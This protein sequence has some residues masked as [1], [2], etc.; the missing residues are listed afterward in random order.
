[1]SL[2]SD[3]G[4]FIGQAQEITDQLHTAKDEVVTSA[5]DA[6]LNGKETV[7]DVATELSSS[8]SSIQETATQA[9]EDI[10]QTLDKTE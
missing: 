9:S 7:A 8:S 10:K 4:S 5:F 3:L 1:M 6:F 2:F